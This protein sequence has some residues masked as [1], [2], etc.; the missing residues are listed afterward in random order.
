MNTFE[1][2]GIQTGDSRSLPHGVARVR[3]FVKDKHVDEDFALPELYEGVPPIEPVYAGFLK[4]DIELRMSE[5][6]KGIIDTSL[7][8]VEHVEKNQY[9]QIITELKE[10][11]N[12]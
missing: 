5:I 2:L 1:V 3:M 8:K 6:E 10:E 12:V 9:E 4:K 11:S 7:S